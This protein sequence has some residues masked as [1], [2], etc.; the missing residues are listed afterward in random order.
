MFEFLIGLC[1]E[2]AEKYKKSEKAK[3]SKYLDSTYKLELKNYEKNLGGVP[4]SLAD[5]ANYYMAFTIKAMATGDRP[6]SP[7]DN[8]FVINGPDSATIRYVWTSAMLLGSLLPNK[9]DHR[10]I[11][12]NS[13]FNE[14]PE[15]GWFAR[16]SSSSL[17]ETAF[18]QY[19]NEDAIRRFLMYSTT[20]AVDAK[21]FEAERLAK[22]QVYKPQPVKRE[23][24]KL[25]VDGLAQFFRELPAS[26]NELDLSRQEL[27]RFGAS[28][29]AEVLKAIPSH[30]T[31]LRL[32]YN[33]LN[34]LSGADLA[35]IFTAIPLNVTCVDI[36]GNNIQYI[37]NSIDRKHRE[38]ADLALAFSGF[39]EGVT[40]LMLANNNL[41]FY[42][43]GLAEVFKA[44]PKS[45]T[46]FYL[47]GNDDER[48]YCSED[49]LVKIFHDISENVISPDTDLITVARR[50][51]REIQRKIESEKRERNECLHH[52]V[53]KFDVTAKE[54]H[55]HLSHGADINYRDDNGYTALM[56]LVDA[57]NDR[58][59]EYLLKQGADP[60]I[61]NNAG[62]LA[63]DLASTGSPVYQLL[64][65]WELRFAVSTGNLAAAQS[66]YRGGAD[67]D[68]QGPDG[69]TALM[70]A[71]SG[72]NQDLVRF[73]VVNGAN[74]NVSL[75]RDDGK[76]VWD[77]AKPTMKALL[78]R[79]SDESEVNATAAVRAESPSVNARAFFS[80]FEEDAEDDGDAARI[81][82]V[83][84][85]RNKNVF[86]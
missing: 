8:M 59:A 83:S 14:K 75:I 47:K 45:I 22:P 80:K 21:Q 4:T 18:K 60:L 11:Y 65:N 7:P 1:A 79:T 63:S 24:Y 37:G 78:V 13:I 25:G 70:I 31:I 39:R 49:D 26:V 68:F 41:A 82:A 10:S 23:L 46:R 54:I 3:K 84:S 52:G 29:L 30:I 73:L 72:D 51:M 16:F 42:H 50:R 15:M 86:H 81:G 48:K 20:E 61:K 71:V 6:L 35:L 12:N 33:E 28:G 43:A 44:M 17:Y 55:S 27:Y 69:S 66:A 5:K 77:L 9:F 56:L 38:D 32:R 76:S 64:K 58:L 85:R 62:E 53:K 74:L 36:S 34:Y 67:I 57:Q 19:L 2:E 40:T